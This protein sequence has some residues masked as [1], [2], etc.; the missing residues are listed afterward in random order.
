MYISVALLVLAII[1]VG[2][3]V[4]YSH[5]L[6][7]QMNQNLWSITIVPENILKY[8]KGSIKCIEVLLNK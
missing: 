7:L 1:A 8:T 4:W 2:I 6:N 5:M 3:V